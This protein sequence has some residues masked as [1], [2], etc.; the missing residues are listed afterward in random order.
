M[1]CA[2]PVVATNIGGN[3]LVVSEGVNGFLVDADNPHLL[4]EK[5]LALLADDSLAQKFGQNSRKLV[6]EK[7]NWNVIARHYID[8]Y[9]TIKK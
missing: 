2:C 6:E 1:S 4:A 9:W 5:V 8:V 3:E 7:Y